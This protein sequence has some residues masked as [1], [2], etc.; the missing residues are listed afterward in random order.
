VRHSI[1]AYDVDTASWVVDQGF[2]LEASFSAFLMALIITAAWAWGSIAK[3]QWIGRGRSDEVEEDLMDLMRRPVH[4]P[5]AEGVT[6]HMATMTDTDTTQRT[7]LVTPLGVGGHPF[8]AGINIQEEDYQ[9]RMQVFTTEP[10]VGGAADDQHRRLQG[11]RLQ[12]PQSTALMRPVLHRTGRRVF[13]SN[14]GPQTIRMTVSDFGTIKLRMVAYCG[15]EEGAGR[16]V[17]QKQL[18]DWYMATHINP[19]SEEAL[20]NEEL[21]LSLVIKRLARR[22]DLVRTISWSAQEGC[23][24]LFAPNPTLLENQPTQ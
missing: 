7:V 22:G 20:L 24:V 10:S 8:V 5:F 3:S 13:D 19:D 12:F 9:V 11:F 2:E 4:R 16:H 21:K 18:I 17:T 23:K 1:T 6:A 14:Q 15:A